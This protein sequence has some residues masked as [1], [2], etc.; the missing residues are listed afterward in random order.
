MTTRPVRSKPHLKNGTTPANGADV[1]LVRKRVSSLKPSPE[2]EQLYRSVYDDPDIDELAES[3][4]KKGL[5]KPL[6]ITADN[7]V[8]DGHRRHAAL[9]LIGRV[10][11]P[12]EVLSVRRAS[13]STSEYV[14]LLREYNR[15]RHKSVA[16]QVREELV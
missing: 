11:A 9:T 10:F 12:C 2:N 6:T 4:K 13:M 8:I 3:I 16:E 1:R 7:F 5:L 15:Y 14:A